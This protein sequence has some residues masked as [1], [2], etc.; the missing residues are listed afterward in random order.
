M[1]VKTDFTAEE[2][3]LLRE[4]P[5]LVALA[6]AMAGA[7]GITGTIAE[8]LS[9]SQALVEAARGANPLVQSLGSRDEILGAQE[10]VRALLQGDLAGLQTRL[11]SLALDRARSAVQLLKTKG[12]GDDLAAYRGFLKAVASRVAQ[13]AKEG[14]FLGFGGE[15]VSD[16][17]EQFLASLDQAIGA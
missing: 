10:G 15:R 12:T 6:V 11:P 8:S 5:Q 4:T 3:N 1:A 17:E 16:R 9:A 13:A 2:W 7:S 14:S